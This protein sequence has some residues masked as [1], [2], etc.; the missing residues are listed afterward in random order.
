MEQFHIN[1]WAVMVCAIANLALGA[2]WYSPLLF[3]KAW[4]KENK[5]TDD[6]IK[7]V[8]P[9]KT[10]SITLL[11][12]VI[13]SYNLAF[14]LGDDKTD[15]IWGTTAG[16]LTGFGFSALIFSV[17]ALFEQRSWKYILING[18]YITIYFTLIGFILG[19]W[20]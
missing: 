3:Y 4:M 13:I 19:T 5:F 17:V 10:Y 6:D 8:N 11:I 1:H 9:A 7:K 20:R 2:L 14:F 15:M 12:S 18:G 16:F